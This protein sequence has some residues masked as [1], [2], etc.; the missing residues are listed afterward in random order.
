MQ[1]IGIIKRLDEVEKKYEEIEKILSDP[2]ISSSD[3]H[4]YS[5]E[6]SEISEVVEIYRQYKKTL[7]EIEENK[8]L[9]QDKELGEL[10]RSELDSLE[11]KRS[12]LEERL[13]IALLPRDPNDS[14]NVFL[15]IRAGTGGEEAALFAGDLFRMYSRYAER[16]GWRVEIMSI[17]E[18]GIGGIKE[19]IAS[20]QGKNVYS[21][22]KHESGVHRVQRVPS[23]EAGGRIHT[24]TATVAVLAEPDDLEVTVDERDLRVD[25]FRASGA[26]GQ[27]VNKTDSAIRI[28]HVPTGI[29]VQCQDERSQHKNRAK[30]MR[31][32][33]AKLYEVE[34]QRRQME[35][36]STRR[37]QV[38]TGERSEKIRTYN[39]PQSRVTDHRIGLTLH[40]IETVLDGD[41]DELVQSLIT[42]Y[43]AESL[44]KSPLY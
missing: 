40:K 30:A 36:S 2:G 10:V 42:Y 19:I 12:Q 25:T 18:T 21:K 8:A 34:E 3:I 38:G 27:H 44:K 26:G 1:E 20:I 13:R 29:V 41:L 14:K 6:R 24:S 43:Q 35:I 5:K 39:F 15:E 4:R 16:N 37:D 9:L 17:N 28:T 31:M 7:Q 32:L 33:K 22:L 11:E 23:T